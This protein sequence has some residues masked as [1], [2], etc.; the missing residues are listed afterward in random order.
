VD[1]QSDF[2]HP[3]VRASADSL[4]EH[5]ASERARMREPLRNPHHEPRVSSE[6]R[7]SATPAAVLIPIVMRD[8]GLTL[9]LTRRHENISYAGHI[10]FPGG[11]VDPEDA[12]PVDTALREAHEEVSLEP[13]RVQ[14]I[15]E[16][17]DYVSHSGFRIHPVVGLVRSLGKLQAAEGEVDEILEFPL[18]HVLDSSSYQLRGSTW[19]EGSAHFYI[20]YRGA[21]VAGPTVS[22]MMGFYEELLHTHAVT[23]DT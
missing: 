1:L 22:M 9:L 3:T 4:V 19:S 21:I 14:V 11:R 15:G 6:H 23:S 18:D 20:E 7:R 12:G 2:T 10:C 16:L 8:S 13:A 17:G 5:F